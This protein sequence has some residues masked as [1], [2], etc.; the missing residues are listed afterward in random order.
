MCS[1]RP[2]H[3]L[4]RHV[5][6]QGLGISPGESLGCWAATEV[7]MQSLWPWGARAT[8]ETPVCQSGR[9]GPVWGLA[10]CPA[11]APLRSIMPLAAAAEAKWMGQNSWRNP[12]PKTVGVK[13]L[14]GLGEK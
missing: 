6:S 2:G 10:R 9:G 14:L 7:E 12:S 1:S 8:V 13:M 11:G 5:L 3:L 4:L